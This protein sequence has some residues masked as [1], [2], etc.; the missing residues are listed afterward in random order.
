MDE[1]PIVDNDI[2]DKAEYYIEPKLKEQ[3][4]L[5]RHIVRNRNFTIMICIEGKPRRGKSTLAIQIGKFLDSTIAEDIDRICFTTDEFRKAVDKYKT[6]DKGKVIILDEAINMFASGESNSVIGRK[7]NKLLMMCGMYNQIYILCLPS[8]Y[9]LNPY[10]RRQQIDVLISME[11]SPEYDKVTKKVKELNRGYWDFYGTTAKDNMLT[12]AKV[13]YDHTSRRPDFY[14]RNFG[15]ITMESVYGKAYEEKKMKAIKLVNGDDE[16]DFTDKEFF[17]KNAISLT[18]EKIN[19]EIIA[20]IFGYKDRSTISKISKKLKLKEKPVN[21]DI[22]I[23]N[24]AP[25]V[26]LLET[27]HQ[28]FSEEG[29]NDE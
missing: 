20:R 4:E 2:N 10:I 25:E 22:V 7:L 5:Y 8:I 29:D 21:S 17:I 18:G 11:L 27:F 12:Y 23:M 3:L 16:T 26:E 6:G 14:G 1:T 15:K 19:Q 13:K 24:G 9:D 28:K